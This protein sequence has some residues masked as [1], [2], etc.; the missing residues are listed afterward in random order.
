VAIST[1]TQ[2]SSCNT[3][4]WLDRKYPELY[5]EL[6]LLK[7]TRKGKK[8]VLNPGPSTTS[9][10]TKEQYLDVL[11]LAVQDKSAK[12]INTVTGVGIDVIR[13]ITSCRRHKWLEV[14]NP[15]DYQKLKLMKH[16]G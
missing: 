6:V 14:V 8:Q 2:I 9:K 16:K 12:D 10:Y 3:H 7:E 15:T 1:I 11:S 13:D 5:T 4:K